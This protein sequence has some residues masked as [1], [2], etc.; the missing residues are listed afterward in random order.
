MDGVSVLG[1]AT[2]LIIF[3]CEAK[4]SDAR[5]LLEF[6]TL[7]D[8]EWNFADSPEAEEMGEFFNRRA[9]GYESHMTEIG[10]D[11]EAYRSTV[12]LAPRFPKPARKTS[13][14]SRLFQRLYR[15]GLIASYSFLF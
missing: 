14:S 13:K 1:V 11:L 10:F 5:P 3:I 15:N 2:E 8:P 9:D 6:E 7:P 4:E 12:G